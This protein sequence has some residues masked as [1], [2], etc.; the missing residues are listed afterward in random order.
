MQL[1]IWDRKT[2]YK[3]PYGDVYTPERIFKEYP[4][5]ED[6]ATILTMRSENVFGAIEFIS[7]LRA[8]YKQIDSTLSDEDF[9]NEVQHIR[10]NPPV[11]AADLATVT[12]SD[13]QLLGQLLTEMN[14]NIL[15][16][17]INA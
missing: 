10:D 14:L 12:K 4:Q 13:I 15:E 17:N 11:P 1:K 8:T 7:D 5:S 6:E 3:A 9:I 2:T 16:G